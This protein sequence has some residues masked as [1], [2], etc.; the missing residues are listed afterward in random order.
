MV[1]FNVGVSGFSY[2][3]WKGTFYAESTK[4]QDLLK[5]Y[6][7]KLNSVEI[8][9]SFYHMPTKTIS[10]KW[11]A[12][13]P[14]NFRFSFKANRKITHFMKLKGVGEE[15]GYFV[16]G[17]IPIKEKLGCILV[18]L[19]PYLQQD[20]ETL[21]TFLNQ[22]PKWASVSLEVRHASWFGTKLNHLLAKY[23]T[24]LCVAETED[25]KPVMEQTASFAYA[26]LRLDSYSKPELNTWAK[27]LV[28][29][30]SSL[31]NC[32]VYFKHD[33]SGETANR[34]ADFAALVGN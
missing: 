24:A 14:E 6:A 13:T 17:L 15:F 28:K 18:Q 11:S 20:L 27:K 26:R 33:E 4:S 10:T 9:S 16:D 3:S 30:S 1:Q 21:E 22:K 34:A 32:F 8:N 2:P 12:S 23:D 25:M 5:A 31:D 29:F 7:T 19:P